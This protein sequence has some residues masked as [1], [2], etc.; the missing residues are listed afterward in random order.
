[1]SEE[2]YVLYVVESLSLLLSRGLGG[3]TGVDALEDAETAEVLESDLEPLEGL[4]C[5][6]GVVRG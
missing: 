4:V 5:R 6:E 3:D 2:G 1:M